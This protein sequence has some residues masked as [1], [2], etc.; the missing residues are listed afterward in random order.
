MFIRSTLLAPGTPAPSF[1][2]LDQEALCADLLTYRQYQG[3]VLVFFASDWL[4]TDL[5]HLK[6]FIT[7]YPRFQAEN[8]AVLGISGINWE[9]IHHLAQR[10]DCPFPLLF[11][12]CARISKHYRT[13]LIPKFISGRAVYGL[14]PGGTVLFAGNSLT[15]DDVL[16]RFSKH[17]ANAALV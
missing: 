1:R 11:D 12:P 14:D 16:L 7:A 8:L 9:T 3:T 6:A 2:L 4:R 17:A 15:P 5:E 10:L 13:M